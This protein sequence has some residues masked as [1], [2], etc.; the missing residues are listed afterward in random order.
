MDPA[1][2][3]STDEWRLP[4][5]AAPPTITELVGRIDEAVA[6]ARASEAAVMTVGAAALDA[7]EQAKRAANLAQRASAAV[8]SSVRRRIVPPPGRPS[9]TTDHSASDGSFSGDPMD[10]FSA[11]ADQ[12]AERL[13]RLQRVPLSQ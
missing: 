12:V 3:A 5:E 11:R 6:T 10:D 2:G 1:A 9:S 4:A 8:A 7:A 13:R